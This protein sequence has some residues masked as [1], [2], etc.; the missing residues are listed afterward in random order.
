MV[1]LWTTGP[2]VDADVLPRA[3]GPY[4]TAGHAVGAP[5]TRS[6]A[7]GAG[8]LGRARA[9]AGEAGRG[10]DAGGGGSWGYP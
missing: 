3:V 4:R 8:G 2:D 9:G 1:Q 6:P 5:V 10:G 7:H